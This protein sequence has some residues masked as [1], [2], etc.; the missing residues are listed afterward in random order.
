MGL[1]LGTSAIKCILVD[2]NGYVIGSHS[3]EYPL[4]QPQPGWA[5]QQP[6]DW[7]NATVAGIRGL[8]AS[9]GVTGA[10]IAG[11][12]FSGQMHGS[13]FLDEAQQV[14]RP[15]LLWC[16]QRT[17]EQCAYIEA[18][19]GEAELGRLTGNGRS[20]VSPRPR[21]F[22]SGSTS[23]SITLAFGICCCR[24]ITSGCA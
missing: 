6:E 19:V 18:T 1:D 2:E 9:S 16:D 13:V 23:R 8:L 5:Q 4:Y 17:A 12:G 11:I 21:S 22:G 10:D 20:P 14:I 24:R 15:A 7:W 3:V